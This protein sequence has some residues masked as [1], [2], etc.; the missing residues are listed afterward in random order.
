MALGKDDLLVLSQGNAMHVVQDKGVHLCESAG[1]RLFFGR[2]V[3]VSSIS[4]RR[5]QKSTKAS[6]LSARLR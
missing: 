6:F 4:G 1:G 2:V 3:P 5:N